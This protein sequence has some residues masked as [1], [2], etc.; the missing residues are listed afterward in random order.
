MT[1][2]IVRCMLLALFVAIACG[3]SVRAQTTTRIGGPYIAAHVVTAP[4]WGRFWFTAGSRYND[5]VRY[6]YASGSG[7]ITSNVIFRIT[8]GGT[9]NY[10]SNIPTSFGFRPTNPVNNQPISYTPFDSLYSTPD[11]MAMVW[12]NLDGIQIVMRFVPEKPTSTL[13][14]GGDMLLEFD[15]RQVTGGSAHTLGIFM[16]LDLVNSDSRVGSQ[17]GDKSSLLTSHGF[18]PSG[19][20]GAKLALPYDSIPDFYHVG[21]FSVSDPLN[22]LFCIH[23][24]RGFSHGGAPLTPP[25]MLAIGDWNQLRW[26]PWNPPA[27]L[28][29]DQWNDV[30]AI[31]RWDDL[32]PYGQVRTAFGQNDRSGNDMFTC[33]DSTLFV[34]IQTSR[35]VS[36]QTP[37]GAYD[38]SYVDVNMWVTNTDDAFPT[39]AIIRL[40]PPMG[41]PSAAPGRLT[42]DPSTPMDQP[43]DLAPRQTIKLHW[44]L[45]I[46][47]TSADT[48]I[49]LQFNVHY[50]GWTKP[51]LF[52]PFL[53][54][55]TPSVNVFGYRP[56]PPPPSD[57]VPPVVQASGAGQTP[58]RY[59]EF[60]TFDRHDGYDYDSGL[61]SIQLVTPTNFRLVPPSFATCDTTVTAT[62]RIEVIDT[63][64]SAVTDI[65][66]T[67]C[68]GNQT[69]LTRNYD[70]RPDN[71]P[72][73]LESITDIGHVADPTCNTRGYDVKLTEQKGEDWGFGSVD[74]NAATLQN[75][76]FELN[77][78]RGDVPISDFD[79]VVTFELKVI[80]TMLAGHAEV[81]AVDYAGNAL[82]PLMFDY[83]PLD[84]TLPPTATVFNGGDGESW[85]IYAADE[86]AWDRGLKEIVPVTVD[87]MDVSA[88]P[89]ITAGQ[90]NATFGVRVIDDSKDA[91][92]VLDIRDVWYDTDPVGHDTAVTIDFT[93]LNDE[94]APNIRFS[95]VPDPNRRLIAVDV[96]DIHQV[97]GGRYPYDLGL[98]SVVI[99]SIT[100]NLRADPIVFNQGDMQM[101]FLV[102]VLDTLALNQQDTICVTATDVFGNTTSD[103]FYYPL[104]PDRLPPTFVG[105]M[106][107]DRSAISGTASDNRA[108]DRGLSSVTVENPVN[109]DP[110]FGVIGLAGAPTKDVTIGVLDPTQPISGT[111]VV[112]DLINDALYSNPDGIPHTVRIP[113]EL[114]VADIRLGMPLVVEGGTEF[115]VAIMA[116]DDFDGSNVRQV[117]FGVTFTGSA[118]FVT[119]D[120]AS[121]VAVPGGLD[122]TVMTDPARSYHDGDTLGR[123]T[124]RAQKPVNVEKFLFGLAPG[125][126]T[127][128]G[129]V[130]DTTRAMAEDN[131]DTV[132]VLRLPP[133]L[134]RA[135]S[136]TT[137][138]V[139][140]T[141]GRVLSSK[142]G[143]AK[144]TGLAILGTH[145]NPVSA[146]ERGS[147]DLDVRDFPASG[148]TVEFIASDGRVVSSSELPP[149]VGH[150]M[151]LRLPLPQ[152]LASGTYVV[153]IAGGG[154]S[155]TTRVIVVR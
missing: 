136:D 51:N 138:Y 79:P 116:A 127:I 92:L 20:Y 60:T 89:T 15:W 76:T 35:V 21:N 86:R 22:T 68:K 153:R 45:D 2:R 147:V 72:P 88:I 154:Q 142:P 39:G 24:L 120:V 33:R 61:Q 75:F 67:D 110:A 96:N 64:Q 111:I 102:E 42:L 119:S 139:N 87:N 106:S 135:T 105:S 117:E 52:A 7:F 108:Y 44:R 81:D 40:P 155:A 74:V 9:E 34:D 146:S 37:G 25:T 82:N 69:V 5:S 54:G 59:W 8:G 10:Y 149:G 107:A 57:T 41:V 141:C 18:F 115:N 104:I 13:D 123:L 109:L 126:G 90:P 93:R 137:A 26:V 14:D 91:H 65:V 19:G 143:G 132:G 56:P 66:V 97:N 50:T 80:D 98:K 73:T 49:P 130:W 114:Q 70:A 148:A 140:G 121:A 29:S 48:L 100:S 1:S 83:C 17:A 16:M 71:S 6:T 122:V 77:Y 32:P 47:P 95:G 31:V 36:Q 30:A 58:T 99:D 103:C 12:K 113:F 28:G 85:Q 131:T 84:D 63:T 3:S 101:R 134:L 78:D 125:T 53:E 94:Y 118:D 133:P 124:F 145:P 43:V 112:T 152:E 62:F 11:T 4:K 38:P 27:T 46:D 23:R 144:L 151:R 150:L 129:G 128:N 55:C